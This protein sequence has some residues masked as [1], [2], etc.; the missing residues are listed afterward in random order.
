M[1][2]MLGVAMTVH[3]SATS[4]KPSNSELSDA[5]KELDELKEQLDKAEDIVDDL[6]SNAYLFNDML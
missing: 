2:L 1:V 6:E 3:A 5:Q 4:T